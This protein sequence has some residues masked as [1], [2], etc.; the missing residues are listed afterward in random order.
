M[1][2][3]NRQLNSLSNNYFDFPF[4]KHSIVDHVHGTIEIGCL[5]SMRARGNIRLLLLVKYAIVVKPV[6][7]S[8]R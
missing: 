4:V 3:R 5:N 6:H 2:E 7:E 1:P 8:T